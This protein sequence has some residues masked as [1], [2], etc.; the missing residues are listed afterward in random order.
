MNGNANKTV[1]K[2][3]TFYHNDTNTSKK[4]QQTYN[5][6]GIYE[7]WKRGNMEWKSFKMH[8]R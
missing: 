5:R 3:N 6:Y 8:T 2:I 4:N 7:P 1:K